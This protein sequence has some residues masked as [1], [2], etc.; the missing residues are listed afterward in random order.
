MNIFLFY[1]C[2]VF[3]LDHNIDFDG[4][5][6]TMTNKATIFLQVSCMYLAGACNHDF[7]WNHLSVVLCVHV[8]RFYLDNVFWSFQAFVWPDLLWWS[9]AVIWSAV[10]KDW[11]VC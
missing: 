6:Q 2:P 10:Q 9:I 4:I 1:Q 11:Y 3:D 8:S 5:H 7:D